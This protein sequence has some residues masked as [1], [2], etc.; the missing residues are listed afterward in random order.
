[1]A[2]RSY[3]RKCLFSCIYNPQI[4]IS[5]TSLFSANFNGDRVKNHPRPRTCPLTKGAEEDRPF[6]LMQS[7]ASAHCVCITVPWLYVTLS[8]SLAFASPVSLGDLGGWMACH[9]GRG[10]MSPSSSRAVSVTVRSSSV[11]DSDI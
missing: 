11:V 8:V 10:S 3:D 1:M 2:T 7:S 5:P 9:R 6:A 4:T